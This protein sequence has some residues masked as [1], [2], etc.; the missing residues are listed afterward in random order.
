[1]YFMEIAYVFDYFEILPVE[2][3]DGTSDGLSES[4]KKDLLLR[5]VSDFWKITYKSSSNMKI[6]A[7]DQSVTLQVLETNNYPIIIVYTENAQTATIDTWV[8]LTEGEILKKESLLPSVTIN[9]FYSEKDALS[10]PEKFQGNVSFFL[11]ETG[12]I[13][14]SL[15]TWMETKLEDKTIKYD[16][17]IEWANGIFVINK[18]LD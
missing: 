14:A 4:E 13:K 3:F 10:N 5:S 11:D 17:F 12:K 9:D 6:H 1:M 16:I 8:Y 2:A 18:Q 15:Y 7:G